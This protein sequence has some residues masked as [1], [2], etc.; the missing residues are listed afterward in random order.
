MKP[1]ANDLPLSNLKVIDVSSIV[2][3]PVIAQLLGDF[4]ADVIKIE[5]PTG[6]SLRKMGEKKDGIPLWWKVVNRNKRCLTLNL[7][8][9]KGND[10][11]KR[12]VSDTDVLIEN[13]R[14]GTMESWGIGW[15][16]LSELNPRLVMVRVTGFG[17]TGPYARRPGFGT[18]VEAMS[19]FAHITG[20]SDGPPT[21][22][23]F[24]LAD[25]VAA[26]YGT[27]STMFALWERDVKGS[28]KGQYIDLAIHEPLFSLL[29]YQPTLYDQ[30][31]II[32]QRSGNRIKESVPRNTYQTI[33]SRWVALSASAPSIA[34]RVL[35][36]TGGVEAENDSRF[37]TQ[38]GR[39][40][41][42]DE[43]DAMVANWI[44]KRTL[45]EVIES[46]E[47]AEAAI[48]PVN[49]IAQ[50]FKDPQFQARQD[51]ISVPDH[52]LGMIKMQNVFPSLSRTPGRIDHAGPGLGEHN[53]E[54]FCGRL[55]M[56][57]T[58]LKELR[59]EGAI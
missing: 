20:E 4:G 27:F 1:E 33:D 21:L 25:G 29:G 50:I 9:P 6:D 39:I 5:H 34:K 3:G 59:T 55:G 11:F 43:I 19:G 53:R 49:D 15:D 16:T 23:P 18:L 45:E 22:P 31:G 48:A 58:D 57:E 24:G 52:E 42:A 41:Y 47:K 36:L 13:F 26:Y 54:V 40:K 32:T 37:Q 17:Q 14:T 44:S 12:L 10:I 35:R 7:K 46:F 38:E 30:L 51:I 2:A 56:S 8:H 28:G